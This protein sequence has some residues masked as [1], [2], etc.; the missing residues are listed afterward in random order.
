MKL[1]KPACNLRSRPKPAII[2]RRL[3]PLLESR[4]RIDREDRRL[5]SI[6]DALVTERRGTTLVVSV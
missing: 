4:Q 5:R 2:R 3:D 1:G 6:V